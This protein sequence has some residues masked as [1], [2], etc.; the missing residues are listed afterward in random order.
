MKITITANFTLQDIQDFYEAEAKKVATDLYTDLVMA[1]AVDTGAL[2]QA[3]DLD[4]NGDPRITNSQPYA[5]RVMEGGH[6]KQTPSGTLTTL[7]DKYTK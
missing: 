4:L 6:S 2:R 3:W 1:T 7:V 5:H